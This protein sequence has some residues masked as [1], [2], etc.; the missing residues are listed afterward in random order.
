MKTIEEIKEKLEAEGVKCT[1]RGS[2][3]YVGKTPCGEAAGYCVAGDHEVYILEHVSK[4]RGEIGQL[5]R[6]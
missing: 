5:L 2:K 1:L 6:K 4:R 3:L